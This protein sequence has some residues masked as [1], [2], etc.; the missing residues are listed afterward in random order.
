MPV[1]RLRAFLGRSGACLLILGF[2]LAF[3]APLLGFQFFP[4]LEDFG[5]RAFMRRYLRCQEF[6]AISEATGEL[7]PGGVLI[8]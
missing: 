4:A 8:V 1:W 2:R 6:M 5:G 7:I 3:R